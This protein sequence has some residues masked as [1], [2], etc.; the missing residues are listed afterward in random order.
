MSNEDLESICERGCNYG[1][2]SLCPHYQEL[3]NNVEPIKR[4]GYGKE[5]KQRTN[6]R[7]NR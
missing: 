6:R 3:N 2:C 7:A 1:S 5:K 4:Y